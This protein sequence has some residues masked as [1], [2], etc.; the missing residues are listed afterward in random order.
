MVAKNSVHGCGERPFPHFLITGI[1][2]IFQSIFWMKFNS[3]FITKHTSRPL[4]LTSALPLSPPLQDLLLI[5]KN[6]E[7][8]STLSDICICF[9]CHLLLFCNICFFGSSQIL[10]FDTSHIIDNQRLSFFLDDAF[11]ITCSYI[12]DSPSHVFIKS[13][14][15]ISTSCRKLIKN[16]ARFEKQYNE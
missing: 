13:F 6:Y 10:D 7:S 3:R 4:W 15:F 14:F 2:I 8:C 11:F 1:L 16:D 5:P 12:D 9:L